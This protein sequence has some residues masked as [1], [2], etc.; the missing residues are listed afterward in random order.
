MAED[1]FWKAV[2]GA[3]PPAA[4]PDER[5]LKASQQQ[6]A[7]PP[8]SSPPPSSPP[9]SVPRPPDE[10]DWNEAV[11]DSDEAVYEDIT[12]Q[13]QA[14]AAAEPVEELR[15]PAEQRQRQQAQQI[16]RRRQRIYGGLG[17]ALVILVLILL[18]SSG[19]GSSVTTSTRPIKVLPTAPIATASSST[20]AATN[21]ATGQQLPNFSIAHPIVP[22]DKSALLTDYHDAVVEAGDHLPPTPH[23][24]AQAQDLLNRAIITIFNPHHLR[25]LQAIGAN[26]PAF[27]RKLQQY[28]GHPV[29]ASTGTPT[30]GT[31]AVFVIGTRVLVRTSSGKS[32]F[33][34]FK[35]IP[36]Q[37]ISPDALG[38]YLN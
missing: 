15:S 31:V 25:A 32:R 5:P 14:T 4:P 18:I 12:A 13:A 2:G 28:L 1:D 20:A 16:R 38:Q 33:A 34:L 8:P 22:L 21:P 6:W 35:I 36:L 26:S 11:A 27:A 7:P 17:T 37:P 9:P 23:Q 29:V 24:L 30:P 3:P 19:S 10:S